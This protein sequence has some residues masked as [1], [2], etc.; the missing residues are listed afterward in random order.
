MKQ[1]ARHDAAVPR[2]GEAKS[3]A[4][5]QTRTEVVNFFLFL[6][7]KGFYFHAQPLSK[8]KYLV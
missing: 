3:S 4:G 2:T 1:P 7:A 6:P 8:I 5:T